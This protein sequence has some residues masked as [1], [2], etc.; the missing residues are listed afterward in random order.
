MVRHSRKTDGVEVGLRTVALLA[1]GYSID[2][3]RQAK[4]AVGDSTCVVAR[5]PEID[6]VPDARE[7]RMV[8]DLF[9]VHRDP[10]EEREG[11]RKILEL[12]D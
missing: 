6:A 4:I 1:P 10:R 3:F 9:G 12:E 7:F 11:L 5:Q 2:A 8:V